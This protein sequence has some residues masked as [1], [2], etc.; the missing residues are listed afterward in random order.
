MLN[1]IVKFVAALSIWYTPLCAA[2]FPSSVSTDANLYVAVNN[3]YTSLSASISASA[4]TLNVLTTA[5]FPAVGFVVIDNEIIKY[6]AKTATSFTGCTRAS[7]GTTAAIHLAGKVVYL[8]IVAS[9][10]NV[11]KDEV[12][13][14]EGYL[15]NGPVSLV[16]SISSST[17]ST[18]IL[19]GS[20]GQ[21]PY[22]TGTNATGFI[23]TG[24]SGQVLITSGTT[25]VWKTLS[26]IDVTMPPYN[27]YGDGSHD[28]TSAIQAAVTAAGMGGVIKMPRGTYRLTSTITMLYNQKLIGDGPESTVIT[29]TGLYGDTIKFGTSNVGYNSAGSCVVQGIW[30]Q[31][32]TQYSS[33]DTS[34]NYQVTDSTSAHV[35]ITAGQT[36]EVT[37]CR[38]WRMP[39]GLILDS[40]TLAKVS[41][42]WFQGVWDH[43]YAAVQEGIASCLV[44]K[45]YSN[46][47]TLVFEKNNF[48]GATSTARTVTW[49]TTTLSQIENVGSR[50]GLLLAG[51]EDLVAEGNYFSGHEISSVKVNMGT[52]VWGLEYRFSGNFFDGV[53]Y[54][55]LL[56]AAVD[57]G[58]TDADVYVRN[59]SF[60]GNQ[61]N[62][63]G[64]SFRALAVSNVMDYTKPIIRSLTMTGNTFNTYVG[65]P[66][67][68]YSVGQASI[69]GN[70]IDDWN[71]QNGSTSDLGWTSAAYINYSS[72]VL[73]MGNS[74]GGVGAHT[75]YGITIGT[76]TTNV[77]QCGN[78]QAAGVVNKSTQSI[79]AYTALTGSKALVSS[80]TGA[81]SESAVSTTTLSYV[82]ATSSI[83]TQLNG[84]LAT[85]AAWTANSPTITSGTGSLTTVSAAGRYIQIGKIV[86]FSCV[87]TLTNNGTG[88][89]YL[90]LPLPVTA[91]GTGYVGHGS[92]TSVD[93]TLNVKF[94]NSSTTVILLYD[95]TYPGVTGHSYTVSITYEAS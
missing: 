77:Y 20:A 67:F 93:K 25:P 58:T 87:I 42:C 11:L 84:K 72:D 90:I 74:L 94:A 85:P 50:Y 26:S 22:Q 24:T 56:S 27:A 55:D 65:T 37:N 63:Q 60:I 18:N 92:D 3:C 19:G 62:G 71:A 82:D 59:V 64:N 66:L 5:N 17:V 75:L 23:S 51:C 2:N 73:F 8:S 7:D 16:G 49:G 61:F 57:F 47:V 30:F 86:H 33:G 52:G 54:A 68:L 32:G 38:F 28:D 44:T 89:A 15:K 31:H 43:D 6:A 1:H 41:R 29:R 35:R 12:I 91:A 70:V 76:N 14:I 34:L 88:G 81:I 21:I 45:T 79:G 13:A 83:Q 36:V 69:S 39:Y 53:G 48:F 46:C 78:S 4:T 9:H 95:G 40:T 80:V 10:H